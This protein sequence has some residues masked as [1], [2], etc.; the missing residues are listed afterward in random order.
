[1]SGQEKQQFGKMRVT[2]EFDREDIHH[3]LSGLVGTAL[4]NALRGLGL[5]MDVPMP[6]E[7]RVEQAETAQ[8]DEGDG[9]FVVNH[10][11]AEDRAPEADVGSNDPMSQQVTQQQEV[12]EHFRGVPSGVSG[13]TEFNTYTAISPQPAM[14]EAADG[15]EKVGRILDAT[16]SYTDGG[17]VVHGS[18]NPV[19]VMASVAMNAILMTNNGIRLKCGRH[20]DSAIDG[21]ETRFSQVATIWLANGF[22]HDF[23]AFGRTK[24]TCS[25]RLFEAMLMYFILTD[26]GYFV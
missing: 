26:D 16:Y 22:E 13:I 2:L 17:F 9:S 25:A 1:M 7:A 24:R 20:M 23:E 5:P 3:Y 8:Q 6:D 12:T 15:K 14:A 19:P 11:S 4:S 18:K 10:Q 21:S